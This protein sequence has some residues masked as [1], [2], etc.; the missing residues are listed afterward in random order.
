MYAFT[1]SCTQ[2]SMCMY[3]HNHKCCILCGPLLYAQPPTEGHSIT[4]QSACTCIPTCVQVGFVEE[5]LAPR[6]HAALQ[7]AREEK[8]EV[9]IN[10]SPVPSLSTLCYPL[11]HP[12]SPS[13]S[14][15]P[16]PPLPLPFPLPS[17]LR[18][19]PLKRSKRLLKR[20]MRRCDWRD[21]VSHLCTW[22]SRLGS[23]IR[24]D[25]FSV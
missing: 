21:L 7:K 8:G 10:S 11:P 16:P 14:P 22:S 18:T 1:L 17:P 25:G 23:C 13:P 2:E 12:P 15:S 5:E 4:W 9:R 6:Y 20:L 24:P 19:S 3:I